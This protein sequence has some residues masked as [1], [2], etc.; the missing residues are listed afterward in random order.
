MKTRTYNKNLCVTK[1]T[2][3]NRLV[4]KRL[5]DTDNNR[6]GKIVDYIKVNNVKLFGNEHQSIGIP[7]F[8][9]G[10]YC[11]YTMRAWGGLMASM[12]GGDYLDWYTKELKE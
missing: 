8:N 7:L 12:W 2:S 1:L 3:S 9:D 4:G 6:H 10:T 11:M 5:V